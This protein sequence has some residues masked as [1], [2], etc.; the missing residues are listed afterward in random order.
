MEK[1]IKVELQEYM[2]SDR[3]IAEAA[4]TSSY[5]L[6][7]KAKKSEIQ[8]TELVKRLANEGHATPFE[9]VVFRF[10]IKL[11]IQSDRQLMTHRIMSS[12]SLSGR[13]RTMPNEFLEIPED[14]KLI[15]NKIDYN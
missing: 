15:F 9:T 7:T 3:T 10:W 1:Q 8:V 14:I 4:W 6:G 11:P 13:Y 5:S 2:G 12:N